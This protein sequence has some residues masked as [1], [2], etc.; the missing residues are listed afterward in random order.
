MSGVKPGLVLRE[1]AHWRMHLFANQCYL[2]RVQWDLVRVTDGSLAGLT[3]EELVALH[4][5]M[6]QFE[7]TITARF[8]PDRFN[9]KQLGNQWRQTHVHGIPRYK[10]PPVWNGIAV[11]DARWGDD[12]YPEADPPLDDEQLSALADDL[13]AALN[14]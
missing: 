6:Q 8:Q 12:P 11:P 5:L 2:G 9:Y 3:P 10:T 13:R 1:T 4:Q 7:A 14:A